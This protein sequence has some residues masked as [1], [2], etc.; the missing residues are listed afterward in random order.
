L[1][2]NVEETLKKKGLYLQS[3]CNSPLQHG[4]KPELDSTG[5]LTTDRIQWY[6][7]I[8]R[9][10]YWA[11]ELG[12]I[13]ILLETALMSQYLALPHKGHLEQVLHIVGYIKSHKKFRIMFDAS[14]PRVNEKWFQKYDWYNFYHD[15]KK[16]YLWICLNQEATQ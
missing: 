15:T 10:I 16:Q 5:E 9:C 1:H 3:K 14:C 12:R 4:Y 11:D 7:E 13:G 6:Q 8:I 2:S